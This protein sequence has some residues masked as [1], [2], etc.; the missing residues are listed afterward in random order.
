MHAASELTS[1]CAALLP[2]CFESAGGNKRVPVSISMLKQIAGRAGRRSSQWSE[3]LATCLNAGD[4]PRLQEA[5][6][7]SRQ[8]PVV[9]RPERDKVD[10]LF[11][12]SSDVEWPNQAALLPCCPALLTA[13]AC[14]LR[15]APPSA[16]FPGAFGPAG[17]PDRRPLPRV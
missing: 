13:N 8:R 9:L 15:L 3:G 1:R 17:H 2:R 12:T 4:V 10:C 11:F 7:V 16:L 5:I 14:Q 6:D